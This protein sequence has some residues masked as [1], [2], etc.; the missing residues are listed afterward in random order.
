MFDRTLRALLLSLGVFTA[1]DSRSV[2]LPCTDAND[3]VSGLCVSGECRSNCV[4][5]PDSCATVVVSENSDA[6]LVSDT[7]DTWLDEENPDWN[8][9]NAA[10]VHTNGA[11]GA[12]RIAL[13]RFDLSALPHDDPPLRAVLSLRVWA[14]NAS[15]LL[16]RIDSVGEDWN[17][18]GQRGSP[19]NSNWTRKG[20]SLPWTLSDCGAPICVGPSPVGEFLPREPG[21]RVEA[22]LDVRAVQGWLE[23]PERNFGLAIS[24]EG[25]DIATFLGSEAEDGLR[26]TLTLFF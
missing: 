3:C 23:T 25:S 21:V 5:F 12:R 14:N 11:P 1:C 6:D 10:L 9:G 4:A 8:W 24:S 16:Q 19:G 13:F 20:E 17:E 2:R 15:S 7:A 22:D 18:G 26:P